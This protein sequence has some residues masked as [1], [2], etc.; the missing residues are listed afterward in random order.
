MAEHKISRVWKDRVTGSITDYAIHEKTSSRTV[1][2]VDKWSKS[3]II[4]ALILKGNSAMT[5]I[6]DYKKRMQVDGETIEIVDGKGG[7]YLRSNARD[8]RTDNLAHLILMN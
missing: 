7:K 6:W 8:E 4:G 2:P 5:W 1:K 3:K